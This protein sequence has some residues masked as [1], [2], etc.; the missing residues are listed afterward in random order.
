VSTVVD[1]NLAQVFAQTVL[2]KNTPP[3][4]TD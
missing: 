3:A 4:G 1:V 2:F